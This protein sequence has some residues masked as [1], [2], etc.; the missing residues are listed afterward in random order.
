MRPFKMHPPYMFLSR[1]I[2]SEASIPKFIIYV[3][4]L[5]LRN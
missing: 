2:F 3:V 1:S 5:I 4:V